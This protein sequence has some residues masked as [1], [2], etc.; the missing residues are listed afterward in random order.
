MSTKITT[1]I[2]LLI[3]SIVLVFIG[4]FIVNGYYQPMVLG[5]AFGMGLPTIIRIVQHIYYHQPN[6]EKQLHQKIVAKTIEKRMNE[7]SC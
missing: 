2:Y 5:A 6:K 3:T 4:L 7:Y 1:W